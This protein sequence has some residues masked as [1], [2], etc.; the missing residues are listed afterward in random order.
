ME[1][2]NWQP[3]HIE[4]ALS[5]PGSAYVMALEVMPGTTIKQAIKLSGLLEQHPEIDLDKN[6][7]GVFNKLREPDDLVNDGDRVE[8]YR[9]LQADPKEARRRRAR[10]QAGN[11]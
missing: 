6:G 9:P 10:R 3:L 7:V 1:T 8:I 2:A 5:Q 11:R 4:V